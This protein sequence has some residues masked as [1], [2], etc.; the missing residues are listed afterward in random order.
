MPHFRQLFSKSEILFLTFLTCVLH[1]HRVEILVSFL[2]YACLAT[3]TRVIF[4]FHMFRSTKHFSTSFYHFSCYSITSHGK[5]G[6]HELF[7]GYFRFT[8]A[9]FQWIYGLRTDVMTHFPTRMTKM[10]KNLTY[11]GFISGPLPVEDM[12]RLSIDRS[13]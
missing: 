2:S 13:C 8:I 9:E 5:G 1:H 11:F 6:D 10:G 3:E 4:P 7:P 12:Y